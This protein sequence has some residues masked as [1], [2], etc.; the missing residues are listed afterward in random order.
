MLLI[1]V[2]HVLPNLMTVQQIQTYSQ[3]YKVQ[4]TPKPRNQSPISFLVLLTSRHN[5]I[6]LKHKKL[7]M[8]HYAQHTLPAVL[9]M[10][11][12]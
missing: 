11:Q 6:C 4:K 12:E 5:V 8:R 9:A 2:L 3:A 1:H 10:L 7:V